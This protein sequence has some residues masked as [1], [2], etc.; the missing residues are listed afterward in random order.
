MATVV[1]KGKRQ[2][3][4]DRVDSE[5][6]L[7]PGDHLTREEFLRIWEQLPH[8]KRAEL[9]GGVVYMPSPQRRE[10]GKTDRRISGWL[11]VYEANTPG[12]EGGSNTT[13]LIGEDCLQP[14][15]YL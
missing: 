13:S 10:H 6:T 4:A 2:K 3:S 5:L 8:I 7:E 9:I 1:A 14:D 11:C 12:C 15:D